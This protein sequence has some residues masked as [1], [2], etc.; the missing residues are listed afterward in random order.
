MVML[1]RVVVVVAEAEL[2]IMAVLKGGDWV[3]AAVLVTSVHPI[4]FP[5]PASTNT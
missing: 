4:C 2:A 3:A 1:E 5:P